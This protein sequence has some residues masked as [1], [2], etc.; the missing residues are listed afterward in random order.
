[1]KNKIDKSIEKDAL[2]N[3]FICLTKEEE[4]KFDNLLMLTIENNPFFVGCK[5]LEKYGF[6]DEEIKVYFETRDMSA[7]SLYY[8]LILEYESNNKPKSAEKLYKCILEDLQNNKYDL[9][10]FHYV[11]NVFEALEMKRA[12]GTVILENALNLINTITKETIMHN[13]VNVSRETLIRWF[14]RDDDLFRWFRQSFYDACF[15]PYPIIF[16]RL[17]K[18]GKHKDLVRIW[19]MLVKDLREI[20]SRNYWNSFNFAKFSIDDFGKVF[21]LYV[22]KK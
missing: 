19:D 20:D 14:G 1:M 2:F 12:S 22:D 7:V 6:E 15:I 18:L 5:A 13:P 21:S 10:Y 4:S 16:D 9:E 8:L 11:N 17:Y 3:R